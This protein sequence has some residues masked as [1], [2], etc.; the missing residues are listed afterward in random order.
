MS[1]NIKKY[2]SKQG[3]V[4]V[5]IGIYILIIIFLT[6]FLVKYQT[7]IIIE[8]IKLDL[9]YAAREA[10]LAFNNQELVY[11]QYEIDENKTRSI[12][13]EVLERNYLKENGSVN[14]ITIVDLQIRYEKEYVKV[15][16]EAEVIFR[17]VVNLFGKNEHKFK[18]KEEVKISLMEYKTGEMYE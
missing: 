8:N 6:V 10:I 3:N 9:F 12:I 18:V 1:K 11:R 15:F 17:G 5:V 16:V 4:I 13:Q 7:N 14:N 2:N